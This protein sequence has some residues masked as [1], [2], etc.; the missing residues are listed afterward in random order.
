VAAWSWLATA[1]AGFAAAAAALPDAVAGAVPTVHHAAATVGLLV[2]KAFRWAETSLTDLLRFARRSAALVARSALKFARAT[3]AARVGS[4]R[5]HAAEDLAAAA[6]RSRATLGTD[7]GAALGDAPACVVH[8][9]VQSVEALAAVRWA[10]RGSN[11][12]AGVE[13]TGVCG[14]TACIADRRTAVGCLA[15]VFVRKVGERR[16]IG[17]R[18]E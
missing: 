12:A 7:F 9:F 16:A 1:D 3:V 11:N 8:A 2:A 13:E 17:D 18:D 10:A 5:A 6:V 15:R 14:T 4:L